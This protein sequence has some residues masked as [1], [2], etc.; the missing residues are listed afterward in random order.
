MTAKLTEADVL[1]LLK[2][3]SPV[4]RAEAAAKIATYYDT[5]GNFGVQERKLAEEIFSIMC[6]DAE[7]RVRAALAAN[8]KECPHLPHAIAQK[9]AS[10]VESVSLPLLKHSSVLTDDDLIEI[11]RSQGEEKQKAIAARPIVSSTVSDALI[12]TRNEVVVGTLVAN[13]GAEISESSMQR[14]LDDFTDSDLVK[15]SM[16]GR[17]S[18]PVEVCERLVTMVS[19][20]LQQEL[21][22]RHELPSEQLSDLILQSR[23]NVT[24]GL[25]GQQGERRDVRRLIVH[26]YRNGRLTPTILLRALCMGDMEFFES[27]IAVMSRIPLPDT[28]QMIHARDRR[29][30]KSIFDK[31]SLPKPLQPAFVAALEVA[32]ETD[33]DGGENDQQRFRRRLIERIITHFDDPDRVMGDDNI[34]YLMARLSRIDTGFALSR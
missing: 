32:S 22:V 18:L 2:D 34:D 1:R 21:L 10:D 6:R 20:Q 27:G 31:A 3:P 12:E 9:L 5:S 11:I 28:R 14:V 7:T 33:Y 25:L 19:E 13:D 17:S 16:V 8:L 24:L 26:L 29:V 30:M 4:S 23:E 15:R